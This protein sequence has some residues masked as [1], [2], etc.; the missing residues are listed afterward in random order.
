[1]PDFQ[2]PST[3]RTYTV[4][5]LT[6]GQQYTFQVSATNSVGTSP[7][8]NTI[9]ATPANVV[10][11]ATNYPG[12]PGDGNYYVG[13]AA[14]SSIAWGEQWTAG[15]GLSVYHEYQGAA[16][17]GIAKIDKCINAGLLA[18]LTFKHSLTPAQI[19]AGD[20]DAGIDAF[21][22]QCLARAPHPIWLT[23]YH[24][25]EDNIGSADR[26][27]FR[28]ATRRYVTRFRAAGVT[29]VA[30]MPIL[31]NP[32]TFQAGSGRDWREWHSDWTGSAWQSTLTM[33]L[34]GMDTY[35]PHPN[36]T[37]SYEFDYMFDQ[38]RLKTEAAGVPEWD[39][40]MPEFG[41]SDRATPLPNWAAWCTIAR[42]YAKAHRVKA[43]VYW[44]NSELSHNELGRYSFGPRPSTS[45]PGTFDPTGIKQQGWNIIANAAKA[46]VAP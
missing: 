34:L 9:T 38:A 36:D 2:V 16:A 10:A 42:D 29:N 14:P 44:D 17:P 26:A 43:F 5:G 3:A 33:D 7:K 20:G 1:M 19:A 23:Y 13:W 18:S 31:M 40:V 11:P 28:A 22:A 45:G 4:T 39:Y 27:S 12:D 24:E 30:W 37:K 46:F 21:A 15:T 6:P 25:P 32:W 41:L 8:S 35:N